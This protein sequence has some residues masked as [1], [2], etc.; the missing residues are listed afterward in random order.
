MPGYEVDEKTK[1]VKQASGNK[2]FCSEGLD[3]TLL[4]DYTKIAKKTIE[5]CSRIVITAKEDGEIDAKTA[6]IIL[7]H[8][9]KLQNGI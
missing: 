3:A 7:L 6:S 8:F 4:D 9:L 5:S 2:S 1:K